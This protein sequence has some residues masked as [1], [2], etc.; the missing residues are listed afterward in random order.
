[1]TTPTTNKTILVTGGCGYIGSHTIVCLLEQS[2]NV[3]VVDNLANSSPKSLDRVRQIAG[4]KDDQADRLVFHQVD[5]CDEEALRKVF[6]TSPKFTSCIHFAG[7]KAVGESTRLPLLYYKNNLGGTFILLELLEEFGCHSI[8]FS[9]SATVY[10][11]ATVPITESSPIG[12]GITNAYGRTK[13][14]IEEILRDY[15]NSKTLDSSAPTTDWSVCILRYFNPVGAHPSGLIGEDPNGIP[16]NLMPYVAQ[17]AIGRRE[18]LTVF[19]NDYP[20]PDGTGVRDYLHVMDLAD[21]HLAALK[22]ICET[23][24]HGSFVFNLGTGNGYSV[25]EMV[26]AMSKACGHEVKYKLGDRRPGD[27]ATCYADPAL[28][29]QELGFKATRNL[30]EMCKD[31][32]NWQSNNPNGFV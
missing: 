19:G 21:G 30:E 15:Y 32:W 5:L 17:V 31:L 1:M 12:T 11:A 2:Y 3:V 14:M 28:A 8:V 22:Y 20:T 29:E 7:L 4:L 16:N 18:Y 23:K 13:Y 27:I 6:E 9:S 25:L 26:S 24:E 10:G